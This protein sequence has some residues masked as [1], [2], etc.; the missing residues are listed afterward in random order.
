MSMEGVQA[1]A[2]VLWQGEGR[3]RHH[4]DLVEAQCLR[5]GTN[6][7]VAS[8]NSSFRCSCRHS[9]TFFRCAQCEATFECGGIGNPCPYCLSV[10]RDGQVTAWT[11]A[12]DQTRHP[13]RVSL[14]PA[15]TPTVETSFDVDRRTLYNF[16]LAAAGGSH[17]QA[18]A[19]C[20]IDFT[21][22][23]ITIHASDGLR[24]VVKESVSYAEVVALQ[25]SGTTTRR[26]AGMIGGGFGVV[27][28]AEGI[29]VASVINSLTTRTKIYTLLRIATTRSEY[30]FVSYSVDSSALQL[31]LTPAQLR[32]RQAHQAPEPP[33]AQPQPQA[34]ANSGLSVA[35]EVRKLAAVRDEGLL[36]EEE[37]AAA[38]ARLLGG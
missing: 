16:T 14:Q 8:E 25:I 33:H 6:Q 26:N 5:C 1:E 34:P 36:T 12:E 29:L 27:G 13:E 18:K 2:S 38:K 17:I 24:D 10:Q 28:A 35:D 11:W 21:S 32:V 9:H 15:W 37:F 4:V 30:V 7:N 19:S 20:T 31:S 22:A 3:N 23:G